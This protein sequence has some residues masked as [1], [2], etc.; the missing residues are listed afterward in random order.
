MR[1]IS[2]PS[3]Q[4]SSRA[5]AAP[6]PYWRTLPASCRR[7]SL[8]WSDGHCASKLLEWAKASVRFTMAIVKRTDDVSGFQVLPDGG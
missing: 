4:I 5:G 2:T 3:P 6:G 8:V 7:I 1:I